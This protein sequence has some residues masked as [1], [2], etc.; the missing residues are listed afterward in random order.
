VLTGVIYDSRAFADESI[1]VSVDL[2]NTNKFP[3]GIYQMTD[4]T[5]TPEAAADAKSM[6]QTYYEEVEALK[7]SGVPNSNAVHQVAEQHGKTDTAVRGAIYQYKTR[8]VG[9]N[10]TAPSGG[11][12]RKQPL[13]VDGLMAQ[14]RSSVEEALALI[15]KEVE[16]ARLAVESAKAH[17]EEKRSSVKTRK[18]ELEKKLAALS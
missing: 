13:G 18:T 1:S 17:Y 16:D 4:T 6:G 5:I 9:G 2:G 10:G 3:G 14:A 8:H 15:D 7:A 12:S 11:R